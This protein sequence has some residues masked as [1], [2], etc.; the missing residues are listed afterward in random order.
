MEENELLDECLKDAPFYGK[1]GGVTFSGGEPLLWTRELEPLILQLHHLG[2]S[3]C[4]ET[5]LFVPTE[6]VKAAIPLLDSFFVD[7][8]ILDA[9][10]CRLMLGGD[11]D[12]FQRNLS[13]LE[14]A[15][16][17]VTYRFPLAKGYSFTPEN[18][19]QLLNFMRAR[20]DATVEVFRCH[21][22]AASK[23]EELGIPVLPP[24]PIPEDEYESFLTDLHTF[25]IH[26]AELTL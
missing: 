13:L 21:D 3:Y 17:A 8:K 1:N 20:P 24:D 26:P 22:L 9:Q 18:R 2:I 19:L 12:L 15:G 25:G 4:A 10:A 5:S 14:S 7:V 16:T 6:L 11:L 23:Y